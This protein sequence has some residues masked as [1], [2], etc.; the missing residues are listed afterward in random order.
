MYLVF[1]PEESSYSVMAE[2]RLVNVKEHLVGET[3]QV[4]EGQ[5][6]FCGEIVAVGNK[7][8]IEKQ[9]SDIERSKAQGKY[10]TDVCVAFTPCSLICTH[11]YAALE[12]VHVHNMLDYPVTVDSHAHVHVHRF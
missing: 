4:K 3:V 11:R 1:W 2:S 10:Y 8:D 7:T 12:S 6:T 5:R 9:L